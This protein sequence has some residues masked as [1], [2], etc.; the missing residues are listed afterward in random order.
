MASENEEISV[1]RLHIN[2]T[3]DSLLAGIDENGNAVGMCDFNNFR[4][5]NNSAER[6]AHHRDGNHFGA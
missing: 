4:H 5:W 2:V 6:I 3:M 1:Q